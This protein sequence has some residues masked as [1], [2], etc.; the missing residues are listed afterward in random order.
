MKAGYDCYCEKP[1]ASTYSDCKLMV[2]A[3]KKLGRKLHFQVSSAMTPQAEIGREYIAEGKIGRPY[4]ANLELA[5]MRRR[6]GYDAPEFTQD[7]LSSRICGHGESID[8]GVYAISHILYLLGNPRIASVYGFSGQ[9]VK[10][11]ASRITVEGG[12]DVDDTVDGMIR[13]EN[14]TNFHCM[15]TSANNMKNYVTSYIMGTGGAMEFLGTD[16]AGYKFAR[17]NLTDDAGFMGEP[18]IIFHEDR[19]DDVTDIPLNCDKSFEIETAKDPKK[20]YRYDNMCQWIAYKLGL[21]SEEEHINT[22][23]LTLN[24]LAITDGIFLSNELGRSVTYDEIAE[25]SPSY[26]IKEQEIGGQMYTYDLTI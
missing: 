25:K 5:L 9:F 19:G 22:V 18:E 26:Y 15:I 6:P 10:Y 23:E 4:L 12:F 11:D 2:E 14:G 20:Y 3:A 17:E 16:M 24:M 1:A 7:F 8:L 13:F 21:I